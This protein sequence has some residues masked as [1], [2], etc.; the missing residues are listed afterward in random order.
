MSDY[1][2]LLKPF[3]LKHLPLRNRV[4]STAHAPHFAEDG[5][6]SERYQL[7]HAEKAKGG[8]GLTIFGGS[9]S[10]AVDSPLSFSQIDISHDRVLPYLQ[11]F[12]KRVHEQGAALFCQITHLGRRGRWD[13]RYWLPL[14]GASK[15]REPL[16]RAFAKEMED[17]DFPRVIRAYGAAARRCRESGLDGCEVIAVA[18]HLIDSFLSPAVN[19]R[20]DQYG[21]SLENRARFGLEVLQ[22]VRR[23]VGPDYVVGLRLSGDELLEG[24]LAAEDCM[25]LA[26]LYGQ[27]GFIDF[28]MSTRPMA[29]RS[30][31]SRP[32]CRTCPIRRRRFSISPAR[33]RR[34]RTC[35]C[36]TPRASAISPLPTARWPRAMSTWSR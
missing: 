10:V 7:Y 29:I 30:A 35:R 4:M 32:C 13:T 33:S 14:I 9:S 21:G 11:N 23:A 1:A 3:K 36:F 34:R 19:Q 16:H 22:E 27:S 17:F 18:H 8:I 6:P 24:G 28:S 25:Q 20:T 5:M 26:M 12:A 31:A 2:D 15:N